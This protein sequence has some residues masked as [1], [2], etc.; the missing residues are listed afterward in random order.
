MNTKLIDFFN[1]ESKELIEEDP[2][3]FLEVLEEY[4]ITELI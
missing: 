4:F 2:T 1:A 3:V